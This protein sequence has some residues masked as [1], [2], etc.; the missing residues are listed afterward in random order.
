MEKVFIRGSAVTCSL[1]HDMDDIIARVKRKECMTTSLPIRIA[2]LDYTRPYYRIPGGEERNKDLEGYF[3]DV[4]HNTVS[5]AIDDSG[6]SAEEIRQS[7]LFFGSTS[8]DMPM[9][10]TTY[11]RDGENG[12]KRLSY[13]SPGY[14]KIAAIVAE[15]FNVSGPCY[16]F[17]TACTSSA[18]CLLYASSMIRTGQIE[19]AIV[20]GYDLFNEVG[21]YGFESMKLIE[22]FAY[23][24]FDKNRIGII[25]GEGCG[26]VVLDGKRGV[27][28]G[29]RFLGGSNACDTFNVTTHNIEGDDIAFVIGDALKNSGL[30][31]H[32]ID[33][34]KAHATGSPANDIT[35]FNGMRKAFGDSLPPFTG[36]KPFIGHTVGACGVIELIIITE[37]VN[38]GFFPATP[39]FEQVDEE[40]NARPIT[41]A[42][43][44]SRGTVMLNYFGFGGNCTS[45]IITN[46]E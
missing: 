40:I 41:E 31:I 14:G 6:L 22:P 20:I 26:A 43:D 27:D 15:R 44:M 8:I 45:Y 16:T 17:T 5:R 23:K 13:E 10:E 12:T 29:F 25:M 35:E 38:R 28:H 32:D 30:T 2:S 34:V 39:G 11:R 36:I 18:N 46:K 37:C 24:P 33:A 7:A 19:R 21:F 1:G 42:L 4:L 3:Y 9:F